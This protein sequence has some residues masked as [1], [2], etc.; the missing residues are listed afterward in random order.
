MT[1]YSLIEGGDNGV[2]DAL[3][4]ARQIAREEIDSIERI[5]KRTLQSFAYIGIAVVAVAGVFGYIGYANLRDAAIVTAENQMRTEVTKEVQ[6][7]LTQENVEG[8]VAD[9]VRNYSATK[10]SEA[11][12][13]ELMMPAQSEMIRSAAADEARNQIN[14][15]FAP[16]HFSEAQSKA[17]IQAVN[18]QPDLDGYP[19]N[20]LPMMMN[21]EAEDYANEIRA[22]VDQT[23]LKMAKDFSGFNK[24]A[25]AGVAIYR[26]ATS[27]EIFARRLQD[28]FKACG[29]DAQIVSAPPNVGV[30]P[31]GEKVPMVIFVGPRHM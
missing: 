8:I 4:F 26:D 6:E 3:T 9:Q 12:H 28:A 25:V 23:K 2:K 27:P 5:H 22:S 1:E 7:K 19:V 29:I 10:M 13:K 16:R 14:V 31:A 21:S 17:F 15:Q 18:S 20:V 30:V 24:T 11:I